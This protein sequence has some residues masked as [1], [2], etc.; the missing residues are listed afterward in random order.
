MKKAVEKLISKAAI[1]KIV[2]NDDL[3]KSKK[4]IALFEGGVEISEIAKLVGVRYQFAYNV[5]SN[6][7][8]KNRLEDQLVQEVKINKKEVILQMYDDGASVKDIARELNTYQNY[9]YQVVNKRSKE[10]IQ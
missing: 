3:S 5:T 10:A 1:A 6:Y 4:I 8:N 9:V 7:I 2:A